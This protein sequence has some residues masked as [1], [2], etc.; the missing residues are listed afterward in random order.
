[1]DQSRKLISVPLSIGCAKSVVKKIAQSAFSELVSME[2]E[3][4]DLTTTQR[5]LASLSQM[6]DWLKK[7]GTVCDVRLVE[8]PDL[9]TLEL[10]IRIQQPM[11][12]D[13]LQKSSLQGTQTLD[14]EHQSLQLC[15]DGRVSAFSG[16]KRLLTG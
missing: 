8:F 16:F 15:P 10:S 7:H 14:Q 2:S 6:Q 12:V 9:S 4:K 13:T 3:H 1:M 5:Y 11:S